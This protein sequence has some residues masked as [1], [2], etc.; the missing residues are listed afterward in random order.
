[1]VI[2][3]QNEKAIALRDEVQSLTLYAFSMLANC[4]YELQ[5]FIAAKEQAV[6]ATIYN[7]YRSD[8]FFLTEDIKKTRTIMELYVEQNIGVDMIYI[9]YFP[10][11]HPLF[12]VFF[13]YHF[14]SNLK[15]RKIA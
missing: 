15:L 1:M 10:C 9:L 7:E 11:F 8:R 13:G 5:V 12:P 14:I 3:D 4:K 2:H 6:E